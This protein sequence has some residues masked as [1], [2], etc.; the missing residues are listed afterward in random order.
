[1]DLDGL[2]GIAL[3]IRG[4]V[5]EEMFCVGEFMPARTAQEG[6]ESVVGDAQAE[7]LFAPVKPKEIGG[8]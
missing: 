3:K 8:E 7:W 1:M 5:M 4:D 2:V 6:L